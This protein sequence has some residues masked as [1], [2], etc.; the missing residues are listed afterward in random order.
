M[1]G[2]QALALRTGAVT[3]RA[4]QAVQGVGEHRLWLAGMGGSPEL[5]LCTPSLPRVLRGAGLAVGGRLA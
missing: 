5:P 4:A 2:L 1:R 3:R